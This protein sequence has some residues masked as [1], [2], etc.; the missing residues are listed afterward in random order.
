MDDPWETLGV[1]RDCDENTLKKAYKKLAMV[2]L[3]TA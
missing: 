1:P 2:L 3:K